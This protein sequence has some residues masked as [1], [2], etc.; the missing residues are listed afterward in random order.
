MGK[1]VKLATKMCT[2]AP[3][4]SANVVPSWSGDVK[5][6]GV[7]TRSSVKELEKKK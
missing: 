6:G 3:E 1:K 5:L 7:S 4:D 2:L